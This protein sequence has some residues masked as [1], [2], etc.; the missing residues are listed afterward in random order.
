MVKVYKCLISGEEF[1]SDAYPIL[2][3][4]DSEG[5]LVSGYGPCSWDFVDSG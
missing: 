4:K 1:I 3:V 2:E 5:N